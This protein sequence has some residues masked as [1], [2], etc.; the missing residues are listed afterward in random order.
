MKFEQGGSFC[1]TWP[2]VTFEGIT[3]GIM[4]LINLNK[5]QVIHRIQLPPDCIEVVDAEISSTYELFI[6]C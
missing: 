1:S 3:K 6:M 4:W 5:P 2:Y